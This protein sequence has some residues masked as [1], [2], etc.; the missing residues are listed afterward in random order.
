MIMGTKFSVGGMQEKLK[1]NNENFT[2]SF[3]GDAHVDVAF[4]AGGYD[5]QISSLSALETG[6]F[7]NEQP[8]LSFQTELFLDILGN[9]PSALIAYR[10]H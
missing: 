1:K 8:N 9:R 4:L 2:R 5:S 10:S 7:V 6:T 3:N